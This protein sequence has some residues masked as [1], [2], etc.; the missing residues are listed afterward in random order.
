MNS[1]EFRLSAK[2]F[3]HAVAFTQ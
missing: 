2:I 1:D 3:N